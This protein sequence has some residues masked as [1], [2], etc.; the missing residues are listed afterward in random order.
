VLDW[1]VWLA[2]EVA[3]GPRTTEMDQIPYT[4]WIP[5]GDPGALARFIKTAI[6]TTGE[7]LFVNYF[8]VQRNEECLRG[9][10]TDSRVSRALANAPNSRVIA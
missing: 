7:P 2:R 10:V 8:R 6:V 3:A 5:F 1:R 4:S 9:P